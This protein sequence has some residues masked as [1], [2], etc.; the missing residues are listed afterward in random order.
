MGHAGYTRLR[1]EGLG[2]TWQQAK[3][4]FARRHVHS[5]T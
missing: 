5:S 3:N 4:D 1:I 2:S